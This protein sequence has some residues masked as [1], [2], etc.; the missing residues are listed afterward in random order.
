MKK[1]FVDD[2]LYL[3]LLTQI[4]YRAAELDIVPAELGARRYIGW[5]WQRRKREIA[6]KK[7]ADAAMLPT[8]TKAR[9]KT[10]S[11]IQTSPKSIGIN[12]RRSSLKIAKLGLTETNWSMKG[13]RQGAKGSGQLWLPETKR[14]VKGTRQGAYGTGEI[15]SS[16]IQ[17]MKSKCTCINCQ[18]LVVKG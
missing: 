11:K 9:T 3:F 17:P 6:D 2:P 16:P 7:K 14:S 10:A 13:A 18:A 15:I 1:M 8:T 12:A 4:G 5:A